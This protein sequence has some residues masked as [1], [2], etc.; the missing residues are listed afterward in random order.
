MHVRMLRHHMF[1][2]YDEAEAIDFPIDEGM[3]NI[4][5]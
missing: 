1:Q 2:E 3:V 5:L 4:N